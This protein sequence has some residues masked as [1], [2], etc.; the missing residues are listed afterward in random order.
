MAFI[1]G[2]IVAAR[3]EIS[4]SL[5]VPGFILGKCYENI[6]RKN[7]FQIEE[8]EPLKLGIQRLSKGKRKRLREKI[9]PEISPEIPK[10]LKSKRVG[11]EWQ[12]NCL[13]HDI[14]DKLY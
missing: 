7:N 10:N 8:R 4:I 12:I 14:L 6:E 13:V 3:T 5:I 11:I 2:G 9:L 1:L